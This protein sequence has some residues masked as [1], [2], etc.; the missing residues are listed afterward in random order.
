VRPA[1]VA[2]ASRNSRKPISNYRNSSSAIK[3]IDAE[4]GRRSAGDPTELP[5][6]IAA[7]MNRRRPFLLY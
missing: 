2:Y 3:V 5:P 4:S 7:F 1:E 6:D